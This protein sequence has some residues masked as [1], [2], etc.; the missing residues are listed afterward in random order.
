MVMP[1]VDPDYL[2]GGEDDVT[3]ALKLPLFRVGPLLSLS[4]TFRTNVLF[5][6]IESFAVRG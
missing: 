3:E 2:E 4:T 5:W 1:E 6:D